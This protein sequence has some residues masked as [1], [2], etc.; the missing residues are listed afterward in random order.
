MN[1]IAEEL[2]KAHAET[3]VNDLHRRAADTIEALQASHLS[4][5][6]SYMRAINQI[7]ALGNKQMAYDYLIL[8]QQRT[9]GEADGKS[10][11]GAPRTNS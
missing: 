8:L 3:A 6:D 4:L 1:G 5:P 11:H 10:T 7:V 2:R 9:E